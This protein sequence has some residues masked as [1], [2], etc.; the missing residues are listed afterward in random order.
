MFLVSGC[1]AV[2]VRSAWVA[3]RRALPWVVARSVCPSVCLS[4][5]RLSA[6][7][8]S[9]RLPWLSAW[10]GVAVR[11]SSDRLVSCARVCA[12]MVLFAPSAVRRGWVAVCVSAPRV[13]RGVPSAVRRGRL[14]ARPSGCPWWL[15]VRGASPA[16]RPGCAVRRAVALCVRRGSAVCRGSAVALR[17]C[18]PSGA[19][20]S[21]SVCLRLC[22]AVSGARSVSLRLLW[23]VG[24]PS[25]A[26]SRARAYRAAVR[27]RARVRYGVLSFLVRACV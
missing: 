23:W 4:V 22:P 17:L 14:A 9:L 11:P 2:W 6:V 5:C 26:P 8:A 7:G 25:L 16:L 12:Y 13:R 18:L 20:T 1:P 15:S 19:L 27:P 24:C 10:V 3:L 21:V